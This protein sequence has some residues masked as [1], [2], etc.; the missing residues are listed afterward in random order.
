MT[1]DISNFLADIAERVRLASDA[2]EEAGRTNVE[3]SIEAGHLLLQAKNDCPHGQWLPFLDRAGVKSR[4]AQI[5][6]R[7][8]RSGAKYELVRICG[9]IRPT[10]DWLDKLTSADSAR[11]H[12]GYRVIKSGRRHRGTVVFHLGIRNAARLLPHRH[13]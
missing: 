5:L 7:L 13:D 10:L 6:M 2:A 8:A 9:G 11:S 3:K 4:W 12:G 1:A